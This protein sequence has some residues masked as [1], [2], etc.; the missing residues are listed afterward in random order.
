MSTKSYTI[1]LGNAIED[2]MLEEQT[3]RL[4]CKPPLQMLLFYLLGNLLVSVR[5]GVVSKAITD[6][7]FE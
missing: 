6:W 1:L 4:V 3:L 5:A 2:I 7:H